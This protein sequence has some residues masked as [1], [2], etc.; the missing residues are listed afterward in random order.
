MRNLPFLKAKKYLERFAEV[1]T[2]SNGNLT[3][4][5]SSQAAHKTILLDAHIDRIGFIVTGIDDDGFVRVDKCGGVMSAHSA[6]VKLFCK[7]SEYQRRCLLYAA[8]PYQWQRGQG[9]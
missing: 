7:K 5:I 8:S 9:G 2:D 4:Y 1:K 3:A 6:T